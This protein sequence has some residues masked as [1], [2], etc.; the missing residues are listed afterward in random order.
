MDIPGT[1]GLEWLRI[2]WV[3][4]SS[5]RGAVHRYVVKDPPCSG[6]QHAFVIRGPKR[7]TI[8]CPYSFDAH[9]VPNDCGELMGAVEPDRFDLDRIAGILR[10][11]WAEY[12]GYGWQRDYDTAALVLKRLGQP[13]P[14]QVMRGGEED[15]RK[16]GG[17]EV[18]KRLEKP[19]K[20]AGK[21]GKFLEWFLE[22]DGSRP[23]RE[24]MAEF[25]MT[26]SNALSYLY[27]LKK[28]HGIGYEL[29]GDVATVQLPDGC[30]NPFDDAE[31]PDDDAVD[32]QTEEEAGEPK[33]DA[34]EEDD[35]WL[36]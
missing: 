14:E 28:D 17:K 12:Q 4:G 31:E 1:E 9:T 30:T 25:G 33:A 26:R 5:P 23:V 2:Y 22:G 19:V 16:K 6:W 32:V 20:R 7:S 8:F 29:V 13:V 15:T 35:S 18:S 27:M 24:A 21:R 11:K 36:D 3:R 34:E 10:S